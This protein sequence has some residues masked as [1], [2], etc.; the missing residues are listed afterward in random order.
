MLQARWDLLPRDK[1]MIA[2]VQTVRGCPKHCSFCS[3]WRTDG[4]K[5]RVRESDAVIEELVQLRRLGFR[6]VALADDNFYPVTL[7][8][9]RMADRRADKSTYN[10]LKAIRDERFALMEALSKLPSGHELLHADHDGSGRG[11]GIPRRDVAG[12]HSRRAGRHRV[13]DAGRTEGRLQGLQPRRRRAGR[14]AAGIPEAR[15]A[16]ARLVHLRL[17]ERQAGDLRCDRGAGAAGQRHARAV[18]DADAVPGHARLPE[19]GSVGR[20]RRRRRSTAFR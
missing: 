12:A 5:P 10:R 3:V 17:A 1:Y 4:Q 14:T 8:D 11:S 2:S 20:R 19:V 13:G 16:R 9:L 6:F 18:R 7:E 15:R